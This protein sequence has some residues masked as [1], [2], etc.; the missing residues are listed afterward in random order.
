MQEHSLHADLKQWY[1]QPGDRV[2][3]YVDGF[4][5]DILRGDLLIE[6]QTRNF[7]ALKRKLT[8]LADRH[9]VRLV[10]P[11][12]QEKWIVRLAADG[13][14]QVG[15]KRS[16][17]RGRPI[18]LFEELVGLAHLMSNPNFSLEVLL[19]QEEEVRCNDGRGSWRRKGWS[20]TD[21]RLIGVVDQL[22]FQFPSDF[23]V[24]LPPTLTEP[25]TNSDLADA[26]GE[27]LYLAQKI[28]Y[29]LRKM[30]LLNVVGKRGKA[31]LYLACDP[32]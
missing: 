15:R 4:L 5:V 13:G 9:P 11:I 8:V 17:K 26:L 32:A 19:S 25:F 12:A 21:R 14:T 16:P 31:L 30:G 3:V 27:R 2:E 23:R 22:L 1:T 10:Y 18:Q 29:C 20:V 6:I 28:T 7:S 24:F